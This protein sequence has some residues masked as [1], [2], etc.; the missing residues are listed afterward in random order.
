MADPADPM[1]TNLV[2]SLQG[3]VQSRDGAVTVVDEHRLR[4]PAMD[5]LV[6]RAVFASSAEAEAARWLI[7][8]IGQALGIRPASIHD[9]YVA[10]G[11]GAYG[12]PATGSKPAPS[13]RSGQALSETKGQALTVPAMNL[14]GLTYDSARAVFRAALKHHVGAMIFEIARSEI[15]YTNQRP[16]EYTAM[17]LAAAIREGFRGPV[18]IQGDHFQVNL[19]KWQTAPTAEIGAVKD[20]I[21]EAIAAGFYNIDIDTST[22]VDLSQPTVFEQQRNNFEVGAELAAYVR[23]HEPKGITISLGGEI[24]EVG[25]KNSTEEE[26]R[27]FTNGFNQA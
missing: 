10:R 1:V 26:L 9:F 11:A 20:L 8:E 7:W 27:A 17:V 2:H 24:G 3:I 12:D 21:V 18:F 19:K 15:G 5:K 16:A 14:R 13:L 23:A 25:G 6:R 4:G 22:L